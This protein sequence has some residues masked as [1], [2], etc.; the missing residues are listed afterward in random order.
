MLLQAWECIFVFILSR[1]GVCVGGG[2]GEGY[3]LVERKPSGRTKQAA[4]EQAG[5]GSGAHK[6]CI[7]WPLR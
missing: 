6:H 1:R 2:V 4:L 5:H 7:S 3:L